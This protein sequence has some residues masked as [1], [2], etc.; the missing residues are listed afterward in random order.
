MKNETMLELLDF[1]GT[2]YFKN[3]TKIYLNHYKQN[4]NDINNNNNNNN[5]NGN[6]HLCQHHQNQSQDKA[7][8][9]WPCGKSSQVY[10]LL[11]F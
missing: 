9:V 3:I 8:E 4:K 7:G 2:L 5:N 1:Y 10:I 11:H 6:H